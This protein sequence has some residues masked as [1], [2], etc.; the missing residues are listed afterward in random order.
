MTSAT[1]PT[2]DP[3]VRPTLRASAWIFVGLAGFACGLTMLWLGMRAVMN[4]GGFCA[5]GGPFVIAHPC[6]EGTVLL[7]VGGIWMAMLLALLYV[8]QV[9]KHRVPSF[10]G[11]LWSALFLSLGWNFL[12]F[13]LNP[14]FGEGVA[15]GFLVCAIV[16]GLMGAVPAWFTLPATVRGFLK[17]TS[18][19]TWRSA[20]PTPRNVREAVR[21]SPRRRSE[22]AAPRD[23]RSQIVKDLER[24]V[25]MHRSGALSDDEFEAAKRRLLGAP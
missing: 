16:F 15:W 22:R 23:G 18:A 10:A 11:L 1:L 24:L 14:P 9:V 8:A 13:G 12:E 17:S 4:I 3:T 19:P 25:E 20:I 6:P 5:E 7:L 21:A 2:V